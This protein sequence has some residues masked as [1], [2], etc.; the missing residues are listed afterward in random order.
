MSNQLKAM[1]IA[2]MK[3]EE[4]RKEMKKLPFFYYFSTF[5]RYIYAICSLGNTL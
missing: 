5:Y 4:D 2:L 3:S 1:S